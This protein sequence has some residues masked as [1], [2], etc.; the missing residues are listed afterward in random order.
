ML[1]INCGTGR[2]EGC[3]VASTAATLPGWR[4][5]F[6]GCCCGICM[7]V[8]GFEP[9]IGVDVTDPL[10]TCGTKW[11]VVATVVATAGA[12]PCCAFA[13]TCGTAKLLAYW[14]MGLSPWHWTKLSTLAILKNEAGS[15]DTIFKMLYNKYKWKFKQYVDV[16]N[17]KFSPGLSPR[18]QSDS[19]DFQRNGFNLSAFLSASIAWAPR[20]LSTQRK[21]G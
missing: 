17:V 4:N 20:S 10:L 1:I 18:W 14:R 19:K 8:C 16:I 12:F 9:V 2:P 15:V 11:F 5:G 6:A 21:Y 3:G 7:L 13:I